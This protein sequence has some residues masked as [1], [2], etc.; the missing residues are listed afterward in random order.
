M[1]SRARVV[2]STLATRDAYPRQ[3][4]EET[5]QFVRYWFDDYARRQLASL[6]TA[7]DRV[8]DEAVRNV[9]WCSFSRLIITKQSGASLAMD[10]AHSRPHKSFERAPTKPFRKFLAAVHRVI[11]NCIDKNSSNRGPATRILEGD[12]RNLPLADASV[13]LVL[14]SPP[15]LNA[16][17]YMRCSKF[18]LVWMG[19]SISG[20]R[21]IRTDSV[22]SE[23]SKASV[24]NG[25]DICNVMS[26]L[27]LRP[28][29]RR[30]M[31]RCSL[32]TYSIC[33]L[34][35]KKLTGFLY[36]VGGSCTWL[37]TTLFGVHMCGT[38]W[39]YQPLHSYPD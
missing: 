10:L 13:D 9:L 15:Y 38:H 17:D 36:R 37:G 12:A 32:G 20:L 25:K 2:F 1:L 6:A 8:R 5:R 3:A 30:R 33:T 22:G 4:D 19:H 24:V 34:L 28:N 11:E 27:R 14:T 35:C 21:K 29:W 31:K 23:A 26:E 7:I 39:S 16:I 18:S